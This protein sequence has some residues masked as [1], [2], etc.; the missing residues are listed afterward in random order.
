MSYT[1]NTPRQLKD[2]ILRRLGAPVI[3]IEI[4]E[5]Q[6][7]DCIQRALELFGEYHYSGLNK[8]YYI[9][10]V[11]EEQAKTG[12]FNLKWPVFAVQKIVR[13]NSSVI[14]G[15]GGG[16]VY[17][18]VQ[19]FVQQIF[20]NNLQ[21]G[22][23]YSQSTLTGM[24][25][26]LQYY[27]QMMSSM[28]LMQDILNPLPEYY[29]NQQNKQLQ[30]YKNFTEGDLLIIE[31]Y[32]KSFN[33]DLKFEDNYNKAGTNIIVGQ[34]QAHQYTETK[35]QNPI[36]YKSDEIVQNLYSTSNEQDVFNNRWIKDY[37]TSLVKE[38]WGQIL[39][40]H[41]GMSLPGGITI[42]GNRLIQEAKEEIEHLREEL[43]QLTLPDMIIY[44]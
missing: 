5:D 8:N 43:Y 41:Q 37:A 32:T 38:L 11:N 7:Y 27:T 31:A 36:Y 26:N 22:Q 19:D 40:K 33:D 10:K 12:L 16:T 28:N 34:S 25:G 35:Y 20:S 24:G 14:A 3:N 9:I 29:Y 39:S 2:L 15:M 42:D 17:N 21:S 13:S 18:W 44:G 30:V 6:I 23:C 1:T 4:T